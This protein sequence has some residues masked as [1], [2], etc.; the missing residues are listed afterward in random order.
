[1]RR[2]LESDS[3][4]ERIEKRIWTRNS[5]LSKVPLRGQRK[6]DHCHGKLKE[7]RISDEK[8]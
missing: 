6:E 3:D 8:T 4:A 5:S 7:E 1:M 2:L